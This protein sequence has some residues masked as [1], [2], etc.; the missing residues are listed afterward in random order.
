MGQHAG[1]VTQVAET[2]KFVFLLVRVVGDHMAQ[3]LKKM[4]VQDVNSLAWDYVQDSKNTPYP[5]ARWVL[6]ALGY[7]ASGQ[8]GEESS[9]KLATKPPGKEHL[10]LQPDVSWLGEIR[11]R[12]HRFKMI[13]LPANSRTTWIKHKATLLTRLTKLTQLQHP[14]SARYLQRF[15]SG[16]QHAGS[17]CQFFQDFST[18]P[19]KLKNNLNMFTQLPIDLSARRTIPKPSVPATCT[20]MSKTYNTCRKGRDINHRELRYS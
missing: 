8:P 14:S 18:I 1:R 4:S 15:L 13:W 9:C 7:Q 6:W 11:L 19:T 12:P 17:I 2:N 10:I 16:S 5:S 20:S 3:K